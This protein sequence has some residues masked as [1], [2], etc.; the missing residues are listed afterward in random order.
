M[1]NS[2]NSK[3][4]PRVSVG[5]IGGK[6]NGKFSVLA[7]GN[8]RPGRTR[9]HNSRNKEDLS[10]GTLRKRL[11][12]ST[13]LDNF[14][15]HLLLGFGYHLSPPGTSINTIK[16]DSYFYCCICTQQLTWLY[17]KELFFF[18][19]LSQQKSPSFPLLESPCSWWILFYGK[20]E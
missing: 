20:T 6:K 12:S 18:Y 3:H 10:I 13:S 2:C 14:D 15:Q 7:E 19:L 5:L 16:L 17:I 4:G 1:H 8:M 9:N 11:L